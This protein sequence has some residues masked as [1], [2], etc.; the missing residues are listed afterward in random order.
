[1]FRHNY[2]KGNNEEVK[3]LIPISRITMNVT[4]EMQID[5]RHIV[6]AIQIP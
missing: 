4:L 6:L 2:I 5:N 3:I 1:M